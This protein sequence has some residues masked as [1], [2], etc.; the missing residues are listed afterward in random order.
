MAEY[1]KEN[2]FNKKM[3]AD[4]ELFRYKEVK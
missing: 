4:V 1:L 2:D 3:P